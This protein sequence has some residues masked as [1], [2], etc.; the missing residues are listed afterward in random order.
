LTGRPIGIISGI[1]DEVL[2][3][4]YSYFYITKVNIGADF[5]EIWAK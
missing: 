3:M 5:D 1:K 2:F 4:P